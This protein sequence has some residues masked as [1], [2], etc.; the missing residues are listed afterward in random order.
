[1]RF[2]CAY[3]RMLVVSPLREVGEEVSACVRRCAGQ[4]T[5]ALGIGQ[6]MGNDG[7]EKTS[8]GTLRPHAKRRL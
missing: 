7:R 4:F 6:S 2:V 1:M 8:S 3:M 5:V